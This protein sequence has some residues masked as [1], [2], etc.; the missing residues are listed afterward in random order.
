[1]STVSTAPSGQLIPILLNLAAAVLGAVGQYLYKLGGA[2][3]GSTPLVRNWPLFSGMALFCVV[4]VLF[5]IAFRLGGRLSVV[6]PVYATTFVWGT[7]LAVWFDHEPWTWMQ[8]GGVAVILL[9]VTMVAL[10][11][12]R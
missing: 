7:L 5:V 9:G 1:M 4:M 3:M 10:G 6:Y 11:Y 8:M 12:A 2:R